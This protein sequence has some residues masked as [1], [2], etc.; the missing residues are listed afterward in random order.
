MSD[1]EFNGTGGIIEGNLGT[2]N[3]NVNLDAALDFD[4]TND[5]VD[6]NYG[7]GVNAQAGFSVSAFIKKDSLGV[8]QMWIGSDTGSNQRFYIGV[9]SNYFAFG[10]ADEGWVNAGQQIT[11]GDW[12]HVCVTATSGAQKLYVNG[13]EITASAKTVSDSFT[14]ASD[15]HLGRLGTGDSYN[16]DGKITD[17]KIFGDVLTAAEVQ[18]L[19][20]KINYDISVGSIDNLTRWFKSNAGS[21]TTIADDSGNSGTAADISGATWIYDQYSVDVYDNSTTTDGTFTVTQGKV[22][23]KALSSLALDGNGDYVNLS[24]TGGDL[25]FGDNSNDSPFTL[26]AWIK[27][28]DATSGTIYGRQD[29]LKF[30]FNSSDKLFL[31]LY[32]NGTGNNEFALSTDA[33]TSIQDK[34]THVTVTYN[35]VGG[36]SANAGINLY[37]DGVAIAMTLGDSGTYTAMHN[38]INADSRIGA[39]AS[40]DYFDGDIRDFK[41]FD[42]E[43]SAEQV[44]SLYS[45]TYPQTPYHGYKMDEGVGQVNATDYGTSSTTINGTLHGNA[46]MGDS[47]GTLDLDGAHSLTIQANGTLSA[48]RGSLLVAG[49]FQYAD[50]ANFTHNN[51]EVEFNGADPDLEM[52]GVHSGRKTPTNPLTF[53]KLRVSTV[54]N[55]LNVYVDFTVENTWTI[56]NDAIYGIAIRQPAFITIGTSSSSGTI[57]GPTSGQG[58]IY[59]AGA[60]TGS[61]VLAPSSVYPWIYTGNDWGWSAS[62]GNTILLENGDYRTALVTDEGY[63]NQT[64]GSNNITIQLTGDMEFDAVTVSSGDTL[65]LNGQRAVIGGVFNVDGT[66]DAD[67]MFILNNAID[68]DGTAFSNANNCTMIFRNTTG[69]NIANDMVGVTNMKTLAF[70]QEAGSTHTIKG[71]N[72][73]TMNGNVIVGGRID[74]E[75]QSQT[76][77][78]DLK[79][80]T[81]G[82]LV[83]GSGTLTCS[84]DFTTS[85]GLIGES[86][87]TLDGTDQHYSTVAAVAVGTNSAW[88]IEGW[89]KRDS[90]VTGNEVFVE[91]KTASNNNNR[92]WVN[93]DTDDVQML[94]Y[95]NS[96]SQAVVATANQGL[97]DGKWHHIAVTYDSTTCQIYVDGKLTT[98]EVISKPVDNTDDRVINVGANVGTYANGFTGSIDEVRIW[99]DVRTE[100]EIRANM[101]SEVSSGDGLVQNWRFNEGTGDSANANVGNSLA[102]R[103]G[104]NSASSQGASLWAGAGT[105]TAGT[106]TLVMAK[107]GTQSIA[108]THLDN[109]FDSLTINAGSTTQMLSVGE[110]GDNALQDINEDLTVNGILKSHPDT[111]SARIRIRDPNATFTVGSSVKTTAL[112]DLARLGFNG[113]GTFNV[114]E[115]TTKFIDITS[116]GTQVSA[117]GDLTITSELQLASGTTFNANTNTINVK[118]TDVNGGTLDLRNS[119]LNFYTGASDTWTM[120]STSTLTTGNTTV[121]GDS[122][123]TPTN[124]PE[125]AGGGFEIV[126]NVSN[127]DVTGDL[128]VIGSVTNCTGN[129]RQ[130]FHTLDTQQLL[131]A[132]EAGDDDLRLTKPALDNA[133]ELQTR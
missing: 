125:S 68:Y 17:V 47:N 40:A 101:F 81:G 102:A 120:S 27:A 23:G 24:N 8:N 50:G 133:L 110:S 33:L 63:H 131:D 107:S 116:S 5:F 76:N 122:T 57:T 39:Y 46:A 49:D 97:N 22:E 54:T 93:I 100:A 10:Y 121:T 67:G 25:E 126:G 119:T 1:I 58:N 85:G 45:N 130:F 44:A 6:L 55:Y 98:S 84:G 37:V 117:S 112:A 129:I 114:P 118:N 60:A 32:D 42:R 90:G 28:D 106:S 41:L 13:V 74:L 86:A 105:F 2:A 35:G 31:A 36:T 19:S 89:M 72:Q 115:F 20:Q 51:G 92:V 43:L 69:G 113:V 16:W 103:D 127:L 66:V 73:Y 53:H 108:Y 61:K 7:N 83:P 56:T 12:Y 11:A 30:G 15:L 71:T 94:I 82:E 78:I 88:T 3:V 77:I 128:T 80:P 34:W 70:L 109:D 95:S 96:G 124:I 14:L 75:N 59:F 104:D 9:R 65:D 132:D 29:E 91:L 123:K 4:G 87:I 52:E 48:P 79:I 38:D 62:N 99:D 26:S 111:T 64:T 18:E 21:G